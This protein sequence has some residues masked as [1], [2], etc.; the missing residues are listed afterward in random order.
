MLVGYGEQYFR[1][2]S[3]QWFKH[4]GL[5]TP[6]ASSAFFPS[7]LNHQET[8]GFL[9]Y[10]SSGYTTENDFSISEEKTISI[11]IKKKKHNETYSSHLT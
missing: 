8:I 9:I 4:D 5:N 7:L 6:A 2:N 10:V 11:T 3:H 1:L